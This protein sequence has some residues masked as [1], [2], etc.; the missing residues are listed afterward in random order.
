MGRKLRTMKPRSAYVR[1]RRNVEG[2]AAI[3]QS[4]SA[5][6]SRCVPS[7]PPVSRAESSVGR[8]GRGRRS[9]ATDWPTSMRRRGRP[10][11]PPRRACPSWNRTPTRPS[12]PP[13][14]PQPSHLHESR[15]TLDNR[16]SQ[17]DDCLRASTIQD[18]LDAMPRD[19]S[20]TKQPVVPRYKVELNPSSELTMHPHTTP[21]RN[22]RELPYPAEFNRPRV[23]E[24]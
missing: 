3:N 2:P 11:T 19:H 23:T 17:T 15:H 9:T 6:G 14:P 16:P 21:E 22:H 4:L 8:S 13:C 18:G 12:P 10:A 5:A 24:Q 7:P 1:R 20:K